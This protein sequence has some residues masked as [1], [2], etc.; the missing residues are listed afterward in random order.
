M[1][2]QSIMQDFLASTKSA[3]SQKPLARSARQ[4]TYTTCR[5]CGSMMIQD[6]KGGLVCIKP[7]SDI[8]NDFSGQSELTDVSR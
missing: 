8:G 5:K 7:H 6:H 3:H 1:N 4:A 2:R